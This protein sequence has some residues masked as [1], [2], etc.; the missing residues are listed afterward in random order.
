MPPGDRLRRTSRRRSLWPIALLLILGI[1]VPSRAVA[2][3]RATSE[4]VKSAYLLRFAE[5]IFWPSE[6]I[7]S[8]FRIGAFDEDSTLV[9]ILRQQTERATVRGKPIQVVLFRSLRDVRDVDILYLNEER[10]LDVTDVVSVV[11]GT[12]VLVVSVEGEPRELTMIN[13]RFNPEKRTYG[14]ETNRQAIE[15]QG[16]VISPELL[17]LGGTRTEARDLFRQ[18]E[19]TVRIERERIADQRRQ[20]ADQE[21][22]LAEQRME[23]ATQRKVIAGQASGILQQRAA[24]DSEA[25]ALAAMQDL[26][27][28]NTQVLDRQRSD[29]RIQQDTI[30]RQQMQMEEQRRTLNTQ[31]AE[32]EVRQQR[33]AEQDTTLEQQTTTIHQQRQT[34]TVTITFLVLV[35]LS[36]FVFWRSYRIIRRFNDELRRKNEQIARQRDELERQAQLLQAA[37]EELESF[38]Y[39]VSHDLRAPLRGI[40]GFS[41]ALSEEYGPAL[42]AQGMDYLRR[43][44][45]STQK[46]S[47]L[48]DDLLK[49][50]RVGR[51]AVQRTHV[52]LVPIIQGI[53]A[54]LQRAEPSR[55]VEV[56][57][58]ESMPA[59]ADPRLVAIV[60][61]NLIGNAWKFT[62]KTSG[63]RIEVRLRID[64]GTAVYVVKDN[65]A[66]FSNQYR[67]RLFAPFHRL[68]NDEEFSG[69]G[70]GLSI[71]KRIIH[72][73][74]GT[75]WADG[76]PGEGATFSFTLPPILEDGRGEEDR[77]SGRG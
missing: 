59:H 23:I 32:I 61:Q 25:T 56:V 30:F 54:D 35:A 21:K 14:F 3:P 71:V 7:R 18:T 76:T 49:L 9:G 44:Q 27:R 45:A 22:T 41:Q 5:K 52:D 47:N 73:H 37:N 69:T 8:A 33:I 74:G 36:A 51:Q 62:A 16:L 42:D 67:D 46:M 65:G 1:F 63:P 4:L 48:I 53:V 10:S 19:D 38:S 77:S 75:I 64:D 39:S 11:S 43:V 40:H 13:L 28:I 58:P 26:L 6:G 50:S 70:I 20:L 24:L 31:R 60:L 66:G 17:V 15:R 57:L 34:L 72:R 12:K 55:P 29:M 2:Q 68:H